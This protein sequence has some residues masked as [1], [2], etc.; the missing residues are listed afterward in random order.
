MP[1]FTTGSGNMGAMN[2]ARNVGLFPGILVLL[3]D[4]G[5]GSLATFLGLKIA[6][7]SG[8]TDLA[9]FAL[10][11]VAGLAAVVGHGWSPYIGFRGGKGLATTLGVGLPLYPIPALFGL[12]ALIGMTLILRRSNLAAAIII[13]TYPL[14]VLFVLRYRGG[15]EDVAFTIFTGVLIIAFVG[16]IKHI[17]SLQKREPPIP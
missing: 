8:V 5:K 15:P 4:I 10:P 2:T 16:L 9:F 6:S 11:L 14:I 7:A 17:P 3:V 1:I 12:V 13:G